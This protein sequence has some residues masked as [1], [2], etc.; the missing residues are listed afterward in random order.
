MEQYAGVLSLIQSSFHVKS[1]KPISEGFQLQKEPQEQLKLQAVTN[2]PSHWLFM[3]GWG[4]DTGGW[5]D[6]WIVLGC[7]VEGWS[8]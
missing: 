2:S 7:G 6:Y 1:K 3:Q 8:E 5:L 4:A